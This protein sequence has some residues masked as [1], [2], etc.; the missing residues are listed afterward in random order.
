MIGYLTKSE[1]GMSQLLKAVN[2]QAGDISNMELI[3]QPASV[4]DKHRE[5]S[6]QE[7]TY[8]ILSLPMTKSSIKVKYLSTIHPHYRDGLL[9]RDLDDISDEESIFHFSAHDYFS[10]RELDCIEGI[11]YMEDEM[12]PDYW[13]EM[14]LADFWS[15]YDIVYGKGKLEDNQKRNHI[16]LQNAVGYIKRRKEKCVLRYYLNYENDED[17]KRGLLILFYPF[18]NEIKDI[19]EKDIDQLYLDNEEAIKER[20][21]LYEKH[22]VMTDIIDSIEKQTREED[23]EDLVDMEDD[24]FI[25]EETTTSTELENFE[26]WAKQQAKKSLSRHKDLTTLIKMEDLRDL[27]IKLNEQQRRILDDFCERLEDD[28]APF[29][30]YIAGEAGTGKSFLVKVMIEA[31]KHLKLTP[32]DDLRKPPALVMAPTANAAYIIS[33][34]T[35]ESSL[36]MLPSKRN[37]FSKRKSSQV[38]NYSF[39][40]EDVSVL[41]CDEISMVGSSKFTRM[42]FQLQDIIGNNDFLGGLSFVAVGDFRQL[43]PVRD[44][45][46]FEKN[47]L[48]DRPSIS[49]SHWDDHFRIYYLSDKMRNQKDPV[50]ASLCD[51]V[52]NGTYTKDDL[53]HLQSC[54]RET[55]SENENENFKNG[56]VSIIVLTNNVR[57]EINAH[58][59]NTLLQQKKSFTSVAMDKCTNLENPPEIPQKLTITQT[60]GLETTIILKNDAP[61]VITSNHPQAKYKEDGIVNG[62]KGYVDSVQVSIKDPERIDVV[63]VVFK[64]MNVGKLLRYDLKHLKK[65]HKPSNENAVPILRQKKTF[66]IQNGEVKFQRHQFPMTLSYAVTAYKCQGDTLDKVIIDFEHLPGEI[67]SVPFGS[68][69][70][71]LT[72]VKEGKNVYL[73]SFHESYITVNKRVEEKIE[74]MRKYK[75]YIFKKIYISDKIF[76][77]DTDEVKLGYFNICGFMCSNHAEYLDSDLNLL[78]LDFLVVSE[79]WLTTDVSNADVINKMKNWKVLKRLDATDNKKHMGLLLLTPKAKINSDNLLYSLEYIEGYSSSN[80]QLLYQ[81]LIMDIK[82]LYRRASFLYI[83]TS[84]NTREVYEI[85]KSLQSCD[86]IIGDLNLNPKILEQKKKLTTICGQNKFMALEE[87][88]TVHNSQLEHV[89]VEKDLKHKCYATAYFNFGSDHKSIGF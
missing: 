55:E 67:K 42:N 54:V 29:Y 30:L 8:R 41:F 63:W 50:F 46:I 9:K 52:G 16:P 59:L 80:G 60:G 82:S 1:S 15:S 23:E 47:H 34:K 69:Y 89:I 66:T 65:V 74:A 88:T 72:R 17:F 14:Y 33:G 3:S 58:K 20:R 51:R 83:R 18:Q 62:A 24:G 10:H 78:Y 75:P 49:P 71:A 53:F 81:G 40:Y 68:F 44:K 56:T 22:K 79:T 35:I 73:K 86:I 27:I 37:T 38:S 21:G 12:Q 5:V 70:V 57:Q 48:D 84:P 39:L 4:L 61:I 87:I 36:G 6:I 76:E 43:P 7:A 32:G 13:R 77:D 26:Q 28:S 85:T 31:I 25:N 11:Q 64:D 45:F 2:E 19:H